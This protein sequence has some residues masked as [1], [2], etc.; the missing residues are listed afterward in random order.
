MR[1][2]PPEADR[3]PEHRGNPVAFKLSRYEDQAKL[4]VYLGLL[5]IAAACC[6]AFL[7][8]QRFELTT[9]YVTY[10]PQKPLL[11]VIGGGLLIGL[12]AGVCGFFLG[13]NGA[14]QKR[15][16]RSRLSWQGFFLSALAIMFTLSTA[17]FFYFTRNP[18]VPPQ[19]FGAQ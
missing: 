11:P 19:P 10:N 7:I 15:N 8:L 5:G 2:V 18:V 9:F 1:R 4:S 16:T 6:A 17:V 3:G 13:L 12:A 14:G